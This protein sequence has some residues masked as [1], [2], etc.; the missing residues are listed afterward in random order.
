MI[1][2]EDNCSLGVECLAASGVEHDLLA[3]LL[4]TFCVS[5]ILTSINSFFLRKRF[6]KTTFWL[7]FVFA[8]ISPLLPAIYH[9]QLSQMRLELDRQKSKLS[10]DNFRRKSKNLETISN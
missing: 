10:N 1:R 3:A 4:I 9:I 6:F 5:I 8:F 2:I 7:N